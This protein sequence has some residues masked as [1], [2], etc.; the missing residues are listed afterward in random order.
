MHLRSFL[1]LKCLLR[2]LRCLLSKCL[3]RLHPWIR[4]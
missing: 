3:L 2:L 4:A 1:R